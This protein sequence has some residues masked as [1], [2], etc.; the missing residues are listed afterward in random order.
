MSATE[1]KRVAIVYGFWG[2]NIGNAFFNIGGRWIAEQLF[3]GR[4]SEILD[5][6]GYRTF[7]RKSKGNPK[8]D[9]GLLSK[10][11]VEYLILQG[12]MLTS[13]FRT[14]WEPT[15]KALQGRGTKII[16]L[17]AAFFHY[18]E[19]EIADATGFLREYPPLIISTRDAD[20]YAHVQ[21][22]APFTYSGIDSAFFAPKAYEPIALDTPPYICMNFDQYPEPNLWV[23]DND[24][25]AA[26]PFDI[27]FETLGKT[28]YARQPSVLK[29]MAGAGQWQCY[30][31]ALADI[32]SMPTE[33]G[34]FQI[35]RTDHRFNPHI[36]WKVYQHPNAVASDEPFTYFS[37]Y[38]GTA[39]TLSDRVHA[40]VATL[41]YG[42]PAM[43]YHPT[44]RARL[45]ARLGLDK[46][47][48]QPCTLDM[49]FLE[50]ERRKEIE[51]LKSA[52][53]A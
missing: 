41:A 17:S 37:L 29:R 34:G 12:P 7:N 1:K 35:I 14:L 13:T 5:Q 47:R 20:S 38:A 22:L 16:L 45:F 23:A 11:D 30:L 21:G 9:F 44:P 26:K 50:A 40:C 46:I 4:V 10:L 33:I 19:K 6:P 18:T 52:V 27:K 36:T 15:F 3:P 24:S 8:K 51:F 25:H 48:T 49:D 39:L 32:R 53:G 28:W 31:A 43:L 2:Q 42:K